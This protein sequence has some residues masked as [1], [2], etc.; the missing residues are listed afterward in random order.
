V[1]ALVLVPLGWSGTAPASLSGRNG[2]I[3]YARSNMPDAGL[4]A[5]APEGGTPQPF[6]PRLLPAFVYSFSWAPDGETIAYRCGGLAVADV[7]TGLTR[8]LTVIGDVS[9]GPSF[10][11]DGSKLVFA[12]PNGG[13]TEVRVVDLD[14][15]NDHRIATVTGAVGYLLWSPDGSHIALQ[16]GDDILTIESDGSQLTDL[17]RGRLSDWSPDGSRILFTNWSIYSM[18]ADGS[19]V[20]LLAS[21][22]VFN[23]NPMWS[24]DGTLI[25]FTRQE[26]AAWTHYGVWLMNADGSNAHRLTDPPPPGYEVVSNWQPLSDLPA[27][28]FTLSVQRVG[29]GGGSVKAS[30]PGGIDCGTTCQMRYLPGEDVF[31]QATADAGSYFAG[32]GGSCSGTFGCRVTLHADASVSAT[33]SPTAP[34]APSLVPL[35][36]QLRG[37]GRGVVTSGPPGISCPTTCTALFSLGSRISLTA[38][39]AP[40]SVLR[41]WSGG[42]TASERR[43]TLTLTAPTTITGTFGAAPVPALGMTA[44]HANVTR[45]GGRWRLRASMSLS[46]PATLRL[47]LKHGQRSLVVRTARL[48]AGHRTLTLILPRT[49][50]PGRYLLELRATSGTLHA[51]RSSTVL[52]GR[53]R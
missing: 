38:A 30:S 9:G 39:P 47:T 48:A 31:L 46:R 11:P 28:R 50:R 17:G 26:D 4:F 51:T 14:G 10:S 22:G 7:A 40:G 16:R 1:L 53:T 52:V 49:V 32:W 20:Q 36:L 19:D 12:H 24:P 25:A 43:C 23:Y 34:P 35:D 37:P 13:D 33:F 6:A 29:V 42:C 2:V 15:A 44:I 45:V 3:V 18:R 21:G 8:Y 41:A 5:I 27:R